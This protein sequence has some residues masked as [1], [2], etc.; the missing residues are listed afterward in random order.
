MKVYNQ[1]KTE[2]IDNPDLTKGKLISDTITIEVPE[3]PE[4]KE[5]GNWV[6]VHNYENGGKDVKWII[7]V[8]G[9]PYQAATTKTED[10]LVYIPYT[11]EELAERNKQELRVKRSELLIAF[12]KYRSAISYGIVTETEEEHA[13]I[14]TWYKAILN[15]DSAAING[16]APTKIAYYLD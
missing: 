9:V 2:I 10:I 4:V 6:T 13:Q 16:E 7:D 14:V 15:L 8:E 5:K 1:T 12:D 11:A 3:V